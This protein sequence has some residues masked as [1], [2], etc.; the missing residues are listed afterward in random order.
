MAAGSASTS[1]CA[2]E[3][4][5]AQGGRPRGGAAQAAVTAEYSPMWSGSW[6][7]FTQVCF[8]GNRVFLQTLQLPKS[9]PQIS[10]QAV[11]TPTL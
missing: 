5:G 1:M 3:S 2:A 7:N 6:T 11:V 10:R 9:I 4:W 8:V